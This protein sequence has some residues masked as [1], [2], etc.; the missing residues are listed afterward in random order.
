MT[1]YAGQV[2]HS[3]RGEA[4]ATPRPTKTIPMLSEARSLINAR[5]LYLVSTPPTPTD[6]S[7]CFS[8][9]KKAQFCWIQQYYTLIYTGR[10]NT[11]RKKIYCCV[12]IFFHGPLHNDVFNSSARANVNASFTSG[13]LPGRSFDGNCSTPARR[14]IPGAERWWYHYMRKAFSWRTPPSPGDLRIRFLAQSFLAHS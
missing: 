5:T 6:E 9:T 12:A 8:K 10:Q 14:H 4:T 11:A 7:S 2:R 3:T 1:I 13:T